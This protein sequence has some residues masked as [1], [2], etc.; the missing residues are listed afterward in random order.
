MSRTKARGH[1]TAYDGTV[2]RSRLEARWAAFFKLL[3]WRATYEPPVEAISYIPDFALPFGGRV[4][5]LVECKPALSLTHKEFVSAA[6]KIY[7]SGLEEDFLLVG[8][9]LFELDYEKKRRVCIGLMREEKDGV[10]LPARCIRQGG[11]WYPTTSMTA[12]SDDPTVADEWLNYLWKEAG[13][14][15][16]WKAPRA[17]S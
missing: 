6:S 4:G 12:E 10:F 15:I 16:Q 2:Y 1:R 14:K 7:R 8:A 3:G 9:R 17:R 13:N 5:L 11:D